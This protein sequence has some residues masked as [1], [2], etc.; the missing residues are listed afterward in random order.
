[1]K[2]HLLICASILLSVSCASVDE[3][4]DGLPERYSQLGLEPLEQV[5]DFEFQ[6][7]R[8]ADRQSVIVRTRGRE[9]YLLVFNKPGFYRNDSVDIVERNLRPRLTR[10]C[11]TRMDEGICRRLAA[12]YQFEDKEQENE[13][14]KFLRAND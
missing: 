3:D 1:M 5:F 12:I 4:L 2:K 8:D 11:V 9:A 14:V 6:R 7:F 13:V 10:V